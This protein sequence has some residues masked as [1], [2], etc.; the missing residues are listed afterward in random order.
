MN[1]ILYRPVVACLLALGAVVPALAAGGEAESHVRF[2]WSQPGVP[3][4][5]SLPL[6][7]DLRIGDVESVSVPSQPQ[8]LGFALEDHPALLRVALTPATGEALSFSAVDLRLE[9]G[10]ELRY[11]FGS[12]AVVSLGGAGPLDFERSLAV[13]A[14]GLYQAV[15]L[16]NN[17]DRELLISGSRYL[18]PGIPEG[19]LLV[20]AG[21]P[22][23]LLSRLEQ[24]MTPAQWREA[25]RLG[26]PYPQLAGFNWLPAS[27]LDL[28]L[29]PREAVVL[30]WTDQSLPA[31]AEFTSFELRP[32]IR[33]L[34]ASGPGES[35]GSRELGLPVTVWRRR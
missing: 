16:R 14:A 22:T 30:A 27:D 15:A 20:G 8:L 7:V 11:R 33:Y 34:L 2:E 10:R 28:R 9:S 35:G 1:R 32:V 5:V 29:S 26:N 18:P 13:T 25:Q 17:G 4:V 24:A 21:E 6:P 23:L 31:S 12:A 3:G 19:R